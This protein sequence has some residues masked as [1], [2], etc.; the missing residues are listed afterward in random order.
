MSDGIAPERAARELAVLRLLCAANLSPE[1]RE[2]LVAQIEA[3]LFREPSH[4]IVYE[5]ICAL[6]RLPADRLRELLP[7]RVTNRGLPDFDY[8]SLL[9]SGPFDSKQAEEVILAL[10]KR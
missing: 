6:R 2:K 9:N 5:E 8:D 4:R 10:R 3:A 7:A 1:V